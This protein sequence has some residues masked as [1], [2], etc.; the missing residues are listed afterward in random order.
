[1]DAKNYPNV[2]NVIKKRT[3]NGQRFLLHGKD[4]AG[5]DVYVTI[6]IESTDTDED[7]LRKVN[8][9][10]IKLN[11]KILGGSFYSI[12]NQ[13]CEYKQYAPNT[14]N[15]VKFLARFCM[16]N[17]KNKVLVKEI[18][19]AKDLKMTTKTLY[20]NK[21]NTF[22]NWMKNIKHI[23]V[24]N[25]LDDVI[26]PKNSIKSK[27]TRCITED[28]KVRL[29]ALFS[30][31]KNIELAL[32]VRLAYFTGARTSSIYEL[33]P[34]SLNNGKI[35]YRNVKCKK[36]YDYPIP[37]NDT[38][39]L[40]LFKV[41]AQ[42]GTMWSHSIESFRT[43]IDRKMR[44]EFGQDV[45]GE[46]LSLH[47]LRHSFAS[48]AIQNGVPPE[49]VARLLDHASINTTLTYYARHSQAQIDEAVNK[50]FG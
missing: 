6:P 27:R 20:L 37:L 38:E 10:R 41:V 3:K 23:N 28:E 11:E 50:I 13:Y 15:C 4:L 48:R 12:F 34:D 49:I 47:S 5:K 24:E 45:R 16:S 26:F 44:K 36:D 31:E 2:K 14:R 30:K 29:F 22:F 9:C 32:F 19:D 8:E 43:I 39:T 33:K 17:K 1:M 18:V 42:K 25:P 7:Y 40:S 35:Y 21:I 46:T